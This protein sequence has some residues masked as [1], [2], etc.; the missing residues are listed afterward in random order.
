LSG[1]ADSAHLHRSP[2]S[3]EIAGLIDHPAG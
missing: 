2:I 1:K 3:E